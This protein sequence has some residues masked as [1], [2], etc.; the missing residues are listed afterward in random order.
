MLRT[1]LRIALGAWGSLLALAGLG[2]AWFSA[3]TW[4]DYSL[5]VL[6]LGTGGVNVLVATAKDLPETPQKRL[7][8]AVG[9]ALAN[10]AGIAAFVFIFDKFFVVVRGN[11]AQPQGKALPSKYPCAKA[12]ADLPTASPMRR[13]SKSSLKT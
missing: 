10:A 9:L 8:G 4:V 7:A 1:A 12:I 11:A 5:A 13:P 3:N 6:W 2:L